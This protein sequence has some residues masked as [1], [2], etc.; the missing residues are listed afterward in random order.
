MSG[1][2]N[3]WC[4]TTEDYPLSPLVL[5]LILEPLTILV[6]LMISVVLHWQSQS[7]NIFMGT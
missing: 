1:P 3:V 4:V 6:N 7:V 5:D 2:I